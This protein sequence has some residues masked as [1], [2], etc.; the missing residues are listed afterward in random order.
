MEYH[1]LVDAV[2]ELGAEVPADDLHL[3]DIYH[4]PNV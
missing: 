3:C 1:D 4:K 2:D